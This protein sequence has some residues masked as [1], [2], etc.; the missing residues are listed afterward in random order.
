MT[1]IFSIVNYEVLPIA[2][3]PLVLRLQVIVVHPWFTPGHTV[4][5]LDGSEAGGHFLIAV[6]ICR[7]A[8]A[9]ALG[10]FGVV[11]ADRALE[12]GGGRLVEVCPMRTGDT[13]V[14]DDHLAITALVAG[15]E[16]D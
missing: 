15:V 10:R 3:E 13:L 1:V 4:R 14:I 2:T 11:L 7:A 16:N 5:L 9:G 8:G 12:T 6:R